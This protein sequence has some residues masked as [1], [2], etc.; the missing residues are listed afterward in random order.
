MRAAVFTSLAAG[1]YMA[2]WA[3]AETIVAS[4]LGVGK[5]EGALAGILAGFWLLARLEGA[6]VASRRLRS[7]NARRLLFLASPL[8]FGL[9]LKLLPSQSLSASL[10]VFAFLTAY[11]GALTASALSTI[12]NE[13]D[14]REWTGAVSVYR[15]LSTLVQAST[16]ATL[17]AWSPG[18]PPITIIVPAGVASLI[19]SASIRGYI[20]SSISLKT[21]ESF[22]DA[23][24][25]MR[26]S[27]RPI[28]GSDLVRMASAAGGL[29][30]AK[31]VLLPHATRES[32]FAGLSAYSIGYLAGILLALK[33]RSPRM[34]SITS[35]TCL[36]L[37]FWSDNSLLALTLVAAALGYSEVAGV[38]LILD[39]KPRMVSQATTLF[40]VWSIIGAIA[41]G[42]FSLALPDRALIATA[43]VAIIGLLYAESV[44]RRERRGF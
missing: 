13:T 4:Q 29:A 43:A 2:I 6:L 8:V 18:D 16:F 21:L 14:D 7:A 24:A 11:M 42:A 3:Y 44:G 36:A 23:A 34:V 5:F 38:L 26:V 32:M 10:A 40:V 31:L 33:I 1:I 39:Y 19:A 28:S 25:F 20:I 17:M 15:G 22:A 30:A 27:R 35:L 12:Y 37:A 9:S 41:V